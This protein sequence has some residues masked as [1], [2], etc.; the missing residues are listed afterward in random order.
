ML[1]KLLGALV[2][3]VLSLSPALATVGQSPLPG[4]GP[5]LQDGTWL[6]GLSGGQNFSYQYGLTAAGTNQAT[7]AQVPSGAYLVQV[8][9]AGSGG[10]TGIAL[11]FC[12]QGT[13]IAVTNNTAYTIDVYPNVFN[14]P[15]VAAQDLIE[16]AGSAGTTSTTMTEYTQKIFSCAKNG[17]WFGK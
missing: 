13:Q 4:I 9:T 6:N 15:I 3:A 10:A 5:A 2:A 1:K 16:T 8:D 17:L 12:Y 14:N 11:P 7:A